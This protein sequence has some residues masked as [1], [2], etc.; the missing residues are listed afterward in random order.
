MRDG[1]QRWEE[2]YVATGLTQVV[3]TTAILCGRQDSAGFT[4]QRVISDDVQWASVLIGVDGS[5]KVSEQVTLQGRFAFTRSAGLNNRDAHYLRN[6]LSEASSFSM[7]GTSTG[8][9]F[10]L[11]ARINIHNG[12]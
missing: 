12:L 5:V 8:V 10:D 11:N 6:D 1:L 3:C 2:S 9:N 7:R 4:G